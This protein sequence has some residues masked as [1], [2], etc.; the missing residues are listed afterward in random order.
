ML[1][2]WFNPENDLALASGRGNYTPPAAARQLHEAG[3]TL[4]L[5]YAGSGDRVLAYG[6]PAAWYDR[7]VRDFNL[8]TDLFDHIASPTTIPSP[9]GWSAYTRTFFKNEGFDDSVL[10]SV[11][12]IEIIRRLSSRATAAEVARRL[13]ERVP[14]LVIRDTA[15]EITEPSELEALL[16]SRTDIVLKSP[17]SSSGRG[18]VMAGDA[19]ID[20]ALRMGCDSIRKQGS[21]MAE[22]CH[23]RALD[24]ARLYECRAGR[25]IDIG[26]S[27]FTTDASGSYTGNLLAPEAER[28]AVVGRYYPRESLAEVTAVLREILEE[29]YAQHY[30]GVLGVDMLVTDDGRLD[31]VVEINVRKTMGYVAN[32]ISSRYLADGVTGTF[33]ISPLR[34]ASP[35]ADDYA[36]SAGRLSGG[37][38]NLVPP[39]GDFAFTVKCHC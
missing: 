3:A 18:V 8:Q 24:F 5:W 33:S 12:D 20:K 27:V 31:A 15:R 29:T 19:G 4:P 28:V 2:H 23:R 39:G 21:V 34:G 26:T 37:L 16:Q 17:W 6:V 1:V 38:L 10:P 7:M 35:P 36:V 22:T 13:A 11:D 30:D 14:H 25:C 32:E 9:W